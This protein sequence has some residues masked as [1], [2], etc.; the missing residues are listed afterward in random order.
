MYCDSLCGVVYMLNFDYILIF[1]CIKLVFLV[2]GYMFFI[3]ISKLEIGGNEDE[4][5]GKEGRVVFVF[6]Y[7]NLVICVFIFSW[8]R[9][10]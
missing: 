9:N 8:G 5:R 7:L 2:N 3:V 1:G 10:V 6:V 4:V